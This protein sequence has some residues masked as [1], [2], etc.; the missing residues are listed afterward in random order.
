M[1][2]FLQ[3]IVPIM[4]LA[5]CQKQTGYET[6]DQ[7]IVKDY[8]ERFNLTLSLRKGHTFCRLNFDCAS[9]CRTFPQPENHLD[10]RIKLSLAFNALEQRAEQS[11]FLLDL[12]RPKPVM[13]IPMKP[14]EFENDA[15][16]DRV[17][18]QCISEQ[19]DRLEKIDQ[20]LGKLN[21]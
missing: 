16:V 3:V 20:L 13:L 10:R 21:N 4:L 15:E 14:P 7:W 1:I 12:P 11:N 9:I 8:E 2:R 17:I 6:L 19:Q 18:L 5:G